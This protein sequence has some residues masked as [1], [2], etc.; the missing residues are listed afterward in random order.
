MIKI[1]FEY[2]LGGID[3]LLYCL[4]IFIVVNYL[5]HILFAIDKHNFSIKALFHVLLCKIAILILVSTTHILDVHLLKSGTKIRNYTIIFYIS[6]EL[7]T[8]LKIISKI[9]VP[10]PEILKKV[11]KCLINNTKL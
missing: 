8:L 2:Y 11:I 5:T 3:D 7:I 4:L 9:G 1:I 6:K 10:I